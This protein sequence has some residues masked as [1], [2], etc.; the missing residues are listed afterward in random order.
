MDRFDEA[1]L[2]S[3]EKFYSNMQRN[4]LVIMI[5]SMQKKYGKY[6]I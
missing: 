4:K 2:P 6:L 5:K 1:E 3:I